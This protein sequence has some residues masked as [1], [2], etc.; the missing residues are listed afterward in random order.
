M[1]CWIFGKTSAKICGFTPNTTTSEL[2]ITSS[3]RVMPNINGKIGA[4]TT[5]ICK[6]DFVT[7]EQFQTAKE[8]FNFSAVI[9]DL[10][11]I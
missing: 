1:A 5:S 7:K 11:V 3:A 10:L 2:K 9:P 8:M 6:N 4:S